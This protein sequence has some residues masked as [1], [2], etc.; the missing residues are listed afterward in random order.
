MDKKAISYDLIHICRKRLPGKEIQKRSWAGIR[1]EIRHKAREEVQAIEAGR[2]GNESLSPADINI[3]LIGKCLELYS[4]HYGA[5][6]DHE[7]NEVNL[8]D[9]L[10]DGDWLFAIESGRSPYLEKFFKYLHISLEENI[11]L[12]KC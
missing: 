10:D 6:V 2:Y 3:I 5:I 4:R 9:A 8:K 11:T 1:Q 7:G 12:W